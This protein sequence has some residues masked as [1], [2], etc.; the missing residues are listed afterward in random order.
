MKPSQAKPSSSTPDG[1]PP[2][3]KRALRESLRALPAPFWVLCA[4]TFVNRFGAFVMTFLS[5]FL[6]ARGIGAGQ[7]A[8][9]LA[10][11]GMGHVVAS[12]AGGYLADRI[13]RR[14]TMGL[15]LLTTAVFTLMIPLAPNYPCL[16]G[17]VL[18]TGLTGALYH[19]AASALVADIVEPGDRV[20]A[21][22]ALRFAI[23]IGWGLGMLVGGLLARHSYMVLFAGDAATS[24]AFG[25]IVL[26]F[27]PHGLRT[28]R[29]QARWSEALPVIARHGEFVTMLVANFLA[30]LVFAQMGTTLSRH[31]LATGHDA[32]VY[33]SVLALNGFMV[34][35]C[36]LFISKWTR[37]TRPRPTMAVGYLLI[38]LGFALNGLGGGVPLLLGAMA[39]FTLGEMIS[40]P[41]NSAYLA[42][43]AP[44]ELRGRYMG[45]MAFTW[46]LALTVGPALGLALYEV[47]PALTW[48]FCLAAGCASAGLLAVTGRRYGDPVAAPV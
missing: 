10:V 27:L 28:S 4:G 18:L 30:S 40:L 13:G 26:R 6:G 15:S 3:P 20:F 21:W 7:T 16:L 43:L 8:L 41:V 36:E 45:V 33:G 24:L 22:V 35:A 44:A 19:P 14:N 31:V 1:P 17:A 47:R 23:N 42:S 38:G 37:A 9:A 34:A 48:L 2:A 46:S 11:F 32:R 29:E 12:L 5:I 25:L 39:V